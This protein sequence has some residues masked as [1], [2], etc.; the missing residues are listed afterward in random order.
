MTNLKLCSIVVKE[1]N[2]ENENGTFTTTYVDKTT[3]SHTEIRKLQDWQ[4]VKTGNYCG[5]TKLNQIGILMKWGSHDIMLLGLDQNI[6]L[7]KYS[8]GRLAFNVNFDIRIILLFFLH[9]ASPAKRGFFENPRMRIHFSFAL[10]YESPMSERHD[11]VHLEEKIQMSKTSAVC[12]HFKLSEDKTKAVCQ[13]C[14]LKLACHNCT[15]SLKNNQLSFIWMFDL[16][17]V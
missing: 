6:C 15:S 13:I 1:V 3:V 5:G 11:S 8:F 7:F 17:A 10:E 4:T 2:L 14:N 16:W 12:E 9:L